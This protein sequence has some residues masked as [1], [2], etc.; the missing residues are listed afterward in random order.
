[1]PVTV[2]DVIKEYDNMALCQ[3][4][5]IAPIY[6][7][8]IVMDQVKNYDVMSLLLVCSSQSGYGTGQRG[9]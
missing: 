8:I 2:M 5:E 6:E 4:E 3:C 7:P 1:M 9:G